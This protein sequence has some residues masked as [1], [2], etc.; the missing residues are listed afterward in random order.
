MTKMPFIKNTIYKFKRLIKKKYFGFIKGHENFSI[1]KLKEIKPLVGN[2]SKN[3]EKE[4]EIS[5]AQI[6][7]DGFC[8]SYGAGRMGLFEIMRV[9]NICK[10]DEI[11]ILGH[12]C[13]VMVNSIKKVGAVPI[14]TDIDSETLGSDF[15]SI[16]KKIT[17]KNKNDNCSTLFW[18]SL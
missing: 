14:Y 5:F 6:I 2:F 3:I 7:G 11:I 9:K 15:K 13:V 12:T 8:V 10:D 17:K 16:A 4:F 1:Q 18:Y